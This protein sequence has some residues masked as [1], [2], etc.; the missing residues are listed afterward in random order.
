MSS[1]VP[2]TN[3]T[4][5]LERLKI[6]FTTRQYD[7]D[8]ND[9]GAQHVADAVG[10][11]LE[12]VYKTILCRGDKTGVFFAVLAGSQELDL[13]SVARLTG[14]RRVELV[15]LKEVQPLTGYI[16]GGCTAIAAKKA[17]P[18]FVEESMMT[19]PEIAVSAGIRG[20]QILLRPT[21]YVDVTHATT[22]PIAMSK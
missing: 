21:D 17:Y 20:M 12:Q 3:A 4:R 13:K 15:P 6:S 5:I 9:L 1:N 18:V 22:G 10:I 2:K 19:H 8:P 11:P 14:N 7:V 16:R